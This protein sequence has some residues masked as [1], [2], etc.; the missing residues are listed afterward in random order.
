MS[1]LKLTQTCGR[2][3]ENWSYWNTDEYGDGDDDDDDDLN[4]MNETQSVLHVLWL[5]F[6]SFVSF[7]FFFFI[8]SLTFP[9]RNNSVSQSPENWHVSHRV[10]ETET[11]KS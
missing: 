3:Y 9:F 4:F 10:L 7:F 11:W 6:S 1:V 5:L 8:W 2:S